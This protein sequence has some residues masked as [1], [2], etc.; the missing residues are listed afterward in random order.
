MNAL[1]LVFTPEMHLGNRTAK[2][3][4]KKYFHKVDF[5]KQKEQEKEV[6]VRP[7]C[8]YTYRFFV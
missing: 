3:N 7:P 1:L 2:E 6:I 8:T 5:Q 4:L